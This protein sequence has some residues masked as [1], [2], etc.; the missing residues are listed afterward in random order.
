MA[1]YYGKSNRKCDGSQI[2]SLLR[3]ITVLFNRFL[4]LWDR[5]FFHESTLV[6]VCVTYEENLSSFDWNGCAGDHPELVVDAVIDVGD[7]VVRQVRSGHRENTLKTQFKTNLN[8]YIGSQESF[9][10]S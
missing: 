7:A 4:L 6:W 10:L 3:T 8:D 5:F 9:G 2:D 1:S